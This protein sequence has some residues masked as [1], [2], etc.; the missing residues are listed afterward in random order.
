MN[1][2]KIYN[3]IDILKVISC[4]AILLYHLGLLKGGYLAVCTF[5]VISGFLNTISAFNKKDFKIKDYYLNRIKKLYI[6]LLIVVG[7]TISITSVIKDINW[8]NL[9]PE[10]MSVLFGYNNFWQLHANLD[11]FTRHISSPFMHF[12]YIAILF[13]LDLIFPWLFIGLKKIK[14]KTYKSVPCVLLSLLSIIATILFYIIGTDKGIML[15]YYHTLTRCFSYLIGLSIGF[16]Y[17]YYK[18][19]TFKRFKKRSWLCYLYLIGLLI[20]FLIGD[21]KNIQFPLFLILATLFSYRYIVYA[22][23]SK[24]ENN[25]LIHYISSITY[26][27]YLVQYPVIFLFQ[28]IE[29]AHQLKT[30]LI[31]ILTI[32]ISLIIH[33]SIEKKQTFKLLRYTIACLL[34]IVSIYG[35]GIF[36]SSEDH[37]SEM[38]A[39]KDELQKNEELLKAKQ[40]E[41][42]K[43]LK[44]EE[45]AWNDALK[46]M[47]SEEENIGNMVKNL[48][49][50]GIGD[51]V[52]LGAVDTLYKEFP[53]GYFDAA[54]SRTAW[55]ANGILQ[56]LKGRGMLKDPIIFNL[57][58]NGDC[59]D[60]CK[61]EI[62]R[63]IENRKLF[64]VNAT[65]DQDVHINDKI[66]NLA[67]RYSN[68]TIIDWEEISKNHK[69]YFVADGIHLTDEGKKAY[70]NAIYESLYETYLNEYKERKKA[71]IEEYNNKVNNRLTLYG[72]DLLLNATEEITESI[73]DVNIIINKDFNSE[74]LINDIKTKLTNKE[75]TN[76]I[77]FL[78]DN[79]AHLTNKEY[80]EI[81]K[82]LEN[83]EVYIVLLE[84]KKIEGATTIDFYKELSI[85]NNYLR[86][87]NIHLTKEGNIALAKMI[88]ET[89]KKSE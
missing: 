88:I 8:I 80:N 86:I 38:L 47:D 71:K 75:L 39:L 70:T 48:N 77:I 87:D 76:R 50:V 36:I 21:A 2:K 17:Y 65:N 54:I 22:L 79:S 15:V 64:W 81:I 5:F 52:M 69:E 67:N 3:K 33:F 25:K 51:S 12:W 14:E 57:G 31:I 10:T 41:Y 23:E 73:E 53:N 16:L 44:S 61:D 1:S 35:L 82:L 55:V 60:Y 30:I 11:Y 56:N 24:E 37:T 43:K 59:P 9:K 78:F 32:I 6:P 28:R 85:N 27:I 46:S 62:M 7:I 72:N 83:K 18:D 58:A 40:E 19:L 68:I 34:A 45:E 63:T 42:A 26:E 4:I 84:D 20:L 89:T 49:V 13:Q 66:K 74:S 29:I